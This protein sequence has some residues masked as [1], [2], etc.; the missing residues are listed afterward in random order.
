VRDAKSEPLWH[1][2]D[3]PRITAILDKARRQPSAWDQLSRQ[4][5]PA[6]IRKYQRLGLSV[7]EMAALL[8]CRD[9]CVRHVLS[10]LQRR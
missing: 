6:R 1:P 4:Q 8:G 7:Q 3:S 9:Q 10:K 5:W 2:D